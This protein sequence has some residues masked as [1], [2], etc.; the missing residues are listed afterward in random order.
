MG[1]G[2][3]V[4]RIWRTFWADCSELSYLLGAVERSGNLETSLSSILS[5]SVNPDAR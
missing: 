5:P 3:G 2:K 1:I 4:N